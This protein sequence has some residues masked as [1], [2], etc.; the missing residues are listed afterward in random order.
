[1][2]KRFTC[3]LCFILFQF[4]G[5]GQDDVNKAELIEKIDASIAYQKFSEADSLIAELDLLRTTP[6][7]SAQSKLLK[8]VVYKNKGELEASAILLKE[9]LHF[10]EDVDN[11]E[12]QLIVINHL[13]QVFNWSGNIKLSNLWYQKG[14]KILENNYFPDFHIYF[15]NNYAINLKEENKLDSALL[16]HQQSERIRIDIGMPSDGITLY[17]MGTIFSMKEEHLKAIEYYN[18]SLAVRYQ[19]QDSSSLVFPT[20]EIALSYIALNDLE[21]G[22]KWLDRAS[23]CPKSHNTQLRFYEI[24]MEYYRKI[25]SFENYDLSMKNYLETYKE[26]LND[27]KMLSLQELNEKYE[28]DKKNEQIKTQDLLIK[29]NDQELQVRDQSIQLKNNLIILISLVGLTILLLA[30]FIWQRSA[31]L[32]KESTIEILQAKIEGEERTKTLISSNMHDFVLSDLHAIRFKLEGLQYLGEID[33]VE[34]KKITEDL[35]L[36]TKE[37]RTICHELSP[38]KND[39]PEIDLTEQIKNNIKTITASCSQNVSFS[40]DTEFNSIVLPNDK[41]NALIAVIKE[42][43]INAIKHADCSVIDATIAITGNSIVLKI[44]DNGKGIE[45]NSKEGIGLSNMLSRAELLKGTINFTNTGNGT[46]LELKF[47][48]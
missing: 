20:N 13:A 27:K 9:I 19:N 6:S 42:G 29:V 12:K 25:G 28:S 3:A 10:Y 14:L 44:T 43:L 33:K 26:I 21:N 40:F 34:L 8:A 24:Q 22:K 38:S 4:F 45:E 48:K 17:N 2:S 39:N 31:R 36:N 16:L 23:L 37:L 32:K 47:P 1:M 7:D 18:Q 46:L 15:L 35:R 30:L 11:Y 5:L 41:K